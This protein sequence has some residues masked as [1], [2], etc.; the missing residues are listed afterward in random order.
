MMRTSKPRATARIV[1]QPAVADPQRGFPPRSRIAI[2]VITWLFTRLLR[3][4]L[5][6]L[7]PRSFV[8]AGHTLSPARKVSLIHCIYRIRM[9]RD[10]LLTPTLGRW[11]SHRQY[12][13]FRLPQ[14]HRLRPI[15]S[16]VMTQVPA[17]TAMVML[18]HLFRRSSFRPYLPLR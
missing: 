2:S 5:L 8:D 18:A 16:H 11:I 1:F 14:V 4:G 15:Q 12:H 10:W 13:Q 7:K 17:T 6:L 3:E 9:E